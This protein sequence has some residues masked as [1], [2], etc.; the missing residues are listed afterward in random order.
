V[1]E[2]VLLTMA[3]AAAGLVLGYSA[4][5][6]LGTLNLQDLP[7]GQEIRL[8][9][10]VVGYT[11]AVS[12]A[13]G[14]ALGLIPVSNVLPANLTTVLREEGRTGTSGRGARTLRR[15]LVVAQVAFAFVL[16]IG[17]GLL[18]A[19]FRRVLAVDPG[20][21]PDGVLTVSITLPRSRYADNK[22]WVAFHAEAL[23][24]LRELPGVAAAGATDWIPMSGSNNDSVIIAEGY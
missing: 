20:L 21:R 24:R 18:F 7:R 8:D 17:A 16:L 10:V 22:A 11:L 2:S 9:A 1:T 6:V 14:F 19:S 3:S 13:I 12:V 23:R 15:A 4:L 5:Q